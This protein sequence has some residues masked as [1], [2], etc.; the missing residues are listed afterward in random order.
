M[1]LQNFDLA[2]ALP[3]LP[4]T[5]RWKYIVIHHSATERGNAQ[6][7]D[8]GHHL[9]GF[10]DGLGYD[11]VVN[12]GTYGKR[13]GQIETGHRWFRQMI[14]AHCSTHGMNENGIGIC[15]V[16]NFSEKE[17]PSQQL[18]STVWL[19]KQLQQRY[20]I[21]NENVIQHREAKNTTECPGKLFPWENFRTMLESKEEDIS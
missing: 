9:R 21:P 17:V 8:K 7:F 14:G 1:P 18:A 13:M 19:V 16:G 4:E 3:Y 20:N 10:P 15:L 6:I 12:N 11:F 5:Q 2:L